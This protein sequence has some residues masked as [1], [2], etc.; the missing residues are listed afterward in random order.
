MTRSIFTRSAAAGALA[1]FALSACGGSPEEAAEG[2]APAVEEEAPAAEVDASDGGGEADESEPKADEADESE[3][4]EGEADEDTGSAPAGESVEVPIDETFTDE[5]T[6]DEITVISAMRDMPSEHD[7]IYIEEGG[8]VLYLQIEVTPGEEFGGVVS[9]R[10]FFIQYG[11]EEE[12]AKSS[13]GEE[14]SEAGY[15]EFERA[16]RRDGATEPAW[17]GFTVEGERQESYTAAYVRPE[18]EILGEDETI[19]EFRHEFE[20]PAP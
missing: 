12:N 15:T 20:I 14:I 3:A 5:E 2:D 17:I 10:D 8:E 16:P 7:S 4:E 9:M 6:G 13:L 1:L 11:D 18:T 19:P